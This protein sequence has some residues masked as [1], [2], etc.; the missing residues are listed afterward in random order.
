MTRKF[1]IETA[2]HSMF[3]ETAATDEQMDGRFEATC[4]DTG[5][6]LILNGW[7]IDE[8]IEEDGCDREDGS[9]EAR[10][11]GVTADTGPAFSLSDVLA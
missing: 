11:L 4:L 5:E 1:Y 2:E 3:V 10:A 9:A 7:M 6:H 8:A